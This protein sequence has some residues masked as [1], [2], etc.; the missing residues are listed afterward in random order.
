MRRSMN[1]SEKT[2]FKFLATAAHSDGH[3]F[4]IF[5]ASWSPLIPK[6][7]I[8]TIARYI[9]G[10][11]RNYPIFLFA[12]RGC[13]LCS[14]FP[15]AENWTEPVHFFLF[16]QPQWLAEQRPP[17]ASVAIR[18]KRPAKILVLNLAHDFFS[19]NKPPRWWQ[20]AFSRISANILH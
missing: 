16:E 13:S 18:E 1:E 6:L 14:L 8:T 20:Y 15:K 5:F 4:F 19:A 10:A 3:D 11:I 12:I 7:E 17:L 2:K 9:L